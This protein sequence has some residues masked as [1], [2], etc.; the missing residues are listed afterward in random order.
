[1]RLCRL[2]AGAPAINAGEPP[3]LPG[4]RLIHLSPL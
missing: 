1:M 3:A 2:E 4:D